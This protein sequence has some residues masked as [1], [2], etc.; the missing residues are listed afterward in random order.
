MPI[1]NERKFV[2][3]PPF[4][5]LENKISESAEKIIVIQQGYL[6]ISK[7]LT[8]R[9]RSK[10]FKKNTSR[11]FNY[12]YKNMFYYM[13]VKRTISGK[14]IEIE[15]EISYEDFHTL[16]YV[17]KNKLNKIRYMINDWEIDFFKDDTL[18]PISNGRGIHHNQTYFAQAEIELP[19]NVDYPDKILD[20]IG[21]DILYG[22]KKGDNRFSN[23]RLSDVRYSTKM[24][25]LLL[26]KK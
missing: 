3:K 24:L 6:H 13:T 17:A 8:V 22:V 12:Q 9:I 20:I 7:K 25:K 21:N 18:M 26:E 14:T 11:E 5:V 16:W 15:N 19:L 2:L 4:D 23:T 10:E 1:E